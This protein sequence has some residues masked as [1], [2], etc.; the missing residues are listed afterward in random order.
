MTESASTTRGPNSA[1]TET[2]PAACP[3]CP[4]PADTHDE[5]GAK[6]CA[7]TAAGNFER[8]CVCVAGE[9]AR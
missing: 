1:D 2:T 5:I 4:H 6:Y 8:G 3:V 9:P 7:A